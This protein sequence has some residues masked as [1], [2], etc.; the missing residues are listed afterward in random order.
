MQI[1]IHVGKN[2]PQKSKSEE[3]YCFEVLDYLFSGL[4]ASPVAWTF[5]MMTF[6]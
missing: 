4:E 5:F 2:D 1:R 6:V 3:M